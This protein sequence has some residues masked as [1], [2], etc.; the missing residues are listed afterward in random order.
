MCTVT[1][2]PYRDKF[3]ITSNRDESPVRKAKGLIS[4]H[5]PGKTEIHFP[6]DEESGGSWI[7]LSESGKV[8]CLLNGAFD[9]YVPAPS[10]RQSRGQVVIDAMLAVD[11]EEFMQDYDLQQIAPF[12]LLLF[13]KPSFSQLIW[14]G[15]ERHITKLDMNEPSIWSSV[16]LY[17]Q[18]VRQWR[19]S[20]FDEWISARKEFNREAI[21]EFHKQTKGD[22]HNDLIMNRNDLVQ[23]LSVTSIALQPDSGSILHMELDQTV[24]EEIMVQYGS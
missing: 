17:T 6:L 21:I 9:S 18:S 11:Q 7:A 4:F 24:R 1:Y 10:Y 23:T 3:F 12:T 19:R 20:I 2:I 22:P 14:D 13:Q 8:A 16:T 5:P 15:A